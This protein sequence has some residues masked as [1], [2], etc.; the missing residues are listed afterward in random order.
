MA[1]LILLATLALGLFTAPALS[2]ELTE[3]SL[4]SKVTN[5]V[6][7]GKTQIPLPRGEWYLSAL[8][9]RRDG[10]YGKMGGV[11]LTQKDNT[12]GFYGIVIS[13]NV[14]SCAH[15][16]R[17]KSICD[18]ENTHYNESDRNYNNRDG[19]CWNV[20][21]FIIDPSKE[22]KKGF[23]KDFFN[24]RNKVMR[25]DGIKRA[26]YIANEFFRTSRCNFSFIRYFINPE[27]FG[28]PPES[29]RWQN[30]AWHRDVIDGDPKRKKFVMAA[31]KVGEELKA[32]VERGFDRELDGWT[33]SIALE[34]E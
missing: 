30:S 20:N 19:K 5:V 16:K 15:S 18:R 24:K 8:H 14:E 21:Q 27:T 11:F 34:F 25:E 9:T 32:V 22:N 33:S 7:M 29:T 12:S 13:T 23:W 2:G 31:Q 28:F 1:K 3:M 26:T 4:G 17:P 10:E 6:N